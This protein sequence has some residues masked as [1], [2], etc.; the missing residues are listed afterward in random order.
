[1]QAYMHLTVKPIEAIQTQEQA[2][3]RT[4]SRLS[5]VNRFLTRSSTYFTDERLR[6]M[7]SPYRYLD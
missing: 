2:Q 7:G 4:E 3:P 6:Q 5:K 1:M